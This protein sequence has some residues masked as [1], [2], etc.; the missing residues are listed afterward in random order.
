MKTFISAAALLLA[1][2]SAF[3]GI[4]SETD[5]FGTMGSN[6]DALIQGSDIETISL[7]GFDTN[8]GTLTGVTIAVEGQVTTGGFIQNN[9]TELAR[10]DF[11]VLVSQNWQVAT[12]AADDYIFA[13]ASF[14]PLLAGASS[15]SGYTLAGGDQ[16]NFNTSTALFNINLTS[17]D[18][19]AFTTGSA[20]DFIFSIGARTNGQAFIDSGVSEFEGVFSTAHYGKVTVTY[21]YDDVITSVPEPTSLAILALGLVGFG[22]RKK[23]SA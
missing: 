18:L 8:L 4:I 14:T 15:V 5:T 3:A 17:V 22:L 12:A 16:F 11:D 9:S 10:A 23:K 7:A 13:N 19:A 2:S 21:S 6:T 20:V 1:S